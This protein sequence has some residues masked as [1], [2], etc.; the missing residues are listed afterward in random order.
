MAR[1]EAMAK[2]WVKA[3]VWVVGAE[4]RPAGVDAEWI[5]KRAESQNRLARLK[6]CEQFPTALTWRFEWHASAV[7]AASRRREKHD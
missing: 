6:R 7:D 3:G 1:V 2:T 5:E 4:V